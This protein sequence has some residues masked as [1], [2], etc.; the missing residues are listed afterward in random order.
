MRAY[1]ALAT[2]LLTSACERPCTPGI[3]IAVGGGLLQSLDQPAEPVIFRFDEGT[4]GSSLPPEPSVLVT[5]PDGTQRAGSADLRSYPTNVQRNQIEATVSL[6]PFEGKNRIQLDFGRGSIATQDAYFFRPTFPSTIAEFE[7]Q[8]IGALRV[9]G[10][11]T[12]CTARNPDGSPDVLEWSDGGV[13]RLAGASLWV[14]PQG[15]LITT[16]QGLGWWAPGAPLSAWRPAAPL[17]SDAIAVASSAS[18]VAIWQQDSVVVLRAAADL[19]QELARVELPPCDGSCR[20][21]AAMAMVDDAVL[22]S[23]SAQQQL[24]VRDGG[25]TLGP[26][27]D[28]GITA[29]RGEAY[30]RCDAQALEWGQFVG[31]GLHVLSSA[32]LPA[33]CGAWPGASSPV[34]ASGRGLLLCPNRDGGRIGWDALAIGA[35]ESGGGCSDGYAYTYSSSIPTRTRVLKYR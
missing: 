1:L 4:C 16:V 3:L 26:L 34:I 19:S 35:G 27:V 22:L 10:S 21:S 9:E 31:A 8:C 33:E 17:T 18:H 30:W 29:A 32:P 7:G 6:S 24:L 12:S 14:L 25:W 28:G 5:G 11:S 15:S 2:M 23:R 13:A 20:L